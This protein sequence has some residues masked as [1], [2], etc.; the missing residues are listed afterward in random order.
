[1]NKSTTVLLCTLVG[2]TVGA[3]TGAASGLL[4]NQGLELYG[5][6]AYGMSGGLAAGGAMLVVFLR[7]RRQA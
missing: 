4:N 6:M 2:L 5:R 7:H 3:I 1:M